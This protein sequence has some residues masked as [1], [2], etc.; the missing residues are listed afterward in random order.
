[1]DD[2]G[3]LVDPFG[4]LQDLENKVFRHATEAF[5]EDPLR[6]LRVARFM[7]RHA[8]E[9]W[10]VHPDTMALMT[11]LSR[12]GEL[13]MLT[14]E[15]VWKELSRALLETT[16]SAFIS[17]LRD[18]EGLVEIL[19]EVDCLFG[20]RQPPEHHPE[21]DTGIHTLLV[22]DQAAKLSDKLEVRFG[23]MVHD[24]GKGI[25]PEEMLPRHLGHELAGVP[26]VEKLCDRLKAPRAI[27]TAG[28]QASEY[29]LNIH[30]AFE[31]KATTLVKMFSALSLKNKP[32]QLEHL[33]LISEADARGRTGLEHRPYPQADYVRHVAK[34]ALAFDAGAVAKAY[35]YKPELIPSQIYNA[36]VS[37]AKA[38]ISAYKAQNRTSD[39]PV[40][41]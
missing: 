3:N 34:G 2:D 17:T 12:S 18:C 23:A 39:G 27:R 20:V 22:M 11:R 38:A 37:A 15:R 33:L 29:H 16:P 32:E 21:I 41:C 40:P 13:K 35:A 14:P 7:A 10:T 31:S 26:L 1:M 4:G 30:R 9:G 24:L 28:V 8:H 5:Q 25:T 36:S 6:V 19:P